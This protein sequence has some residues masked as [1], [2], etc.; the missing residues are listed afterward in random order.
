VRIRVSY[1]GN[2]SVFETTAP[3]V[4]VG[5]SQEGD[6]VDLD[7]TP[8]QAVSRPHARI[9]TEGSQYWIEDLNSMQGTQVSGTEI[10]G[11]GRWRLGVGE[12]V[13]IG[14]TTLVV[15]LL[16]A[17]RAS[18]L[19]PEHIG[20]IQATLDATQPALLRPDATADMQ[21]RLK[22]LYDLPLEFALDPQLDTVLQKILERVVQIVPGAARGALL[23][24]D[25]TTGDLLLRAHVPKGNPAVSL[26]LARR[27]MEERQAF[28]W[29][30]GQ[31]NSSPSILQQNIASAMYAPLLWKGSTLGVVC[32]DN[33]KACAAFEAGD[34]QLMAAV[35][36]HA[37]MAVTVHHIQE[38]QR[39]NAVLLSRL[40]TNFSPNIR[41]RLLEKARHGNLRLGGEK[42]EVTI[43]FSDIRGFTG[44]CAGMEPED[45]V[46]MLNSYIPALIEPIFKND[47]TIDKFVG[48]AILAVFGSPEVDVQQHEKAVQAAVGMQAAIEELNRSRQARGELTC[49]IGVGL[50]CGKVLHGFI[51]S[52]ERMEFTV[53]GD[54]VNRTARYC[55]AA[56]AGEVLISPELHRRVWG[57]IQAEPKTIPTKH[58]GNFEAYRINGLK[59][60]SGLK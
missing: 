31:E 7:L 37:A 59:P 24:K 5:R 8:D 50:H 36:Q 11:R 14:R 58:E 48:D 38:E 46:D 33:C 44:L 30:Q 22:L 6:P 26:K 15:E 53:I 16:S 13:R 42:S 10:R 20:D 18:T 23:I 51:G 34:L 25:Q 41:T 49:G 47:G 60:P 55:A 19:P 39:Q 57:L 21:N 32:V 45:A 17:L 29:N 52:V 4:M 43:L 2:V 35:G 12:T 40:L 54:A 56:E 27:A 3:Q 28:T 9:S 1:Q